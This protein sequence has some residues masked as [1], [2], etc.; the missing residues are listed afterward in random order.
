MAETL[1]VELHSRTQAWAVIQQQVFPFLK[2]V[3]Q[4]GGRWVLTISRRKRTPPQNRRYWGRGVLAQIAEQAAVNGKLYGAETWHELFKRKFIGVV[5]LPD[6]SVVH[7]ST[8]R[9]VM[10]RCDVPAA[11][12]VKH[13][14]VRSKKL[15][16]ACREIPCQH[17]GIADGTVVAAHSN[18]LAHGKGRSIK[19]SDQFVASL[20]HRCHGDIDQGSYLTKDERVAIWTAAHER[21]VKEL[22]RLGLWPKNVP[23]P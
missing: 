11:P 12:V 9:A 23:Q 18:A 15:L 19:A 4:G 16:E 20:C 6:G 2:A 1:T 7:K 5:E 21:T 13:Q 3:L 10:V 22:N 14:Y 17:C 8:S